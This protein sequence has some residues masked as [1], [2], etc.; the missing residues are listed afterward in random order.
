M[1]LRPFLAILFASAAS[2]AHGAASVQ[3]LTP[4]AMSVAGGETK[5]FSVRFFNALGQPSAGEA[6]RFSNDVCGR[7]PNGGFFMDTVT[8][9]TGTATLG[10]TASNPAGITCW[11]TATAGVEA[12]FDVVTYQD[13]GVTIAATTLPA[14]PRAGQPYTLNVSARFGAYRLANVDVAAKVISGTSSA[15][16]SAAAQ[17][18]GDSGTAQFQVTPDARF[19]D[20]AIEASFKAHVQRIDMT[21]GAD[22]MQDM[23]WAGP[24]ENGWG[25]SIVQHPSPVLFSVIYAYDASGKPTWYVMPG[26]TWNAAHTSITGPVYSPRGAPYTAYDAAKFVPGAP[27]GTV[28]LAFSDLNNAVLDYTIQGVTGRK[29]ITRQAFAQQDFAFSANVADMYWGGPAQN[30]WGISVIQQYRALF[31]VWYT[32]DASGAPTWYVMPNGAWSD[33]NT[34][35]GRI[36]RT[37]GS[38]WLGGA[39]DPAK[40]QAVDVGS[41]SLRFGIEGATLIYVIDQK[42]GTM[43]LVRQPF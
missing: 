38:P 33:V 37:T 35:E 27:V 1:P 10:F 31:S 36:Y 4:R 32:Y 39:Y 19:G 14:T 25:M 24:A 29:S 26:G 28:T 23:W 11:L 6:V 18:T 21:M 9:A 20:Y 30:G 3:L 15:L 40:L 41:F 42:G 12:R 2:L 5:A 43:A 13:S 17:S 8:D 7:F 22:A 34:Y 16:I